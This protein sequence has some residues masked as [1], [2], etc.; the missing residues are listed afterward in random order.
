[1]LSSKL[2]S[3]LYINNHIDR[4]LKRKKQNKE[5]SSSS[6]KR[7]KRSSTAPFDFKKNCLICGE[8]TC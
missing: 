8:A 3:G 6:V 2:L 7:S 1:M 4:Y 5:S